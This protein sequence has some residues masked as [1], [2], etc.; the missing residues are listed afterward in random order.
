MTD[1]EFELSLLKKSKSDAMF[2]GI[3]MMVFITTNVFLIIAY[4][5]I[6]GT[7]ITSI[8]DIISLGLTVLC[9]VLSIWGIY[10]A[11]SDWKDADRRILKLMNEEGD[12][13]GK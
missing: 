6:H 2:F 3:S 12:I 8:L 7:N 10:D 1:K 11:V 9:G 4:L 13:D 5:K